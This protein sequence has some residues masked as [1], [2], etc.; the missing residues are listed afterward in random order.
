MTVLCSLKNINVSFGQKTIFRNAQFQI[1]HNDKIG[2]IGL[3]GMGKSTLFKILNQDFVPDIS[4]D[5][6]VF[7]KAT[8][9]LGP[10][11][12]YSVFLVPQKFEIPKSKTAGQT[13]V[14]KVHDYFLHYYPEFKELCNLLDAIDHKL[15]SGQYAEAELE[16]LSHQRIDIHDKLE[17]L[18]FY[19]IQNSYESYLK[20]FGL[21]ALEKEVT[22]LSGGEQR[23]ILLA[24]GLTSKANLIL[25][26]EPT[27]HL[28]I[29]TINIF[30]DEILKSTKTHVIISHDRYLLSKVTNRIFHINKGQILSYKGTYADYMEFVEQSEETRKQ[31]LQKL[32]NS[33]TRELAWMRQGVRA[34]G[35]KSKKRIEGFYDLS[36][37]VEDLK[38][39]AKKSMD[40]LINSSQRKTRKLCE[41]IDVDF[42]YS[43][44][45]IF[46]G[47]TLS[48]YKGDK[49]GVLG[50]NGVGK[51]TL[52]KII[53]SDLFPTS[54]NIKL[55]DDLKSCYF[56]QLREE[57]PLDKTP[58]QLLGE[59]EDFI[60]FKNGR[61]LHVASYFQNYLFNQSELYRPLS[62]FSGGELNRLQLAMNLK[63]EADVWIFDEPTNDL[64]IES[65][66]I[67]EKK[68]SEFEGTVIVISHDRT[69][70][71]NVTNK[72]W[73]VENKNIT[74]FDV[75]YSQVAPYLEALQ[76]EKEL[77]SE[78]ARESARE[79]ERE[80]E[81]E[82]KKEQQEI[83]KSE[84][85]K[86]NEKVD[87]VIISTSSQ[88]P[89]HIE[90]K[91]ANVNTN[92]LKKK[93][94]SLNKSIAK[95][96]AAIAQIDD[97]LSR[98]DYSNLDAEKSELVG[99]LSQ[100]KDNLEEELLS[101][102]EELE[103]N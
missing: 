98:F 99:K 90:T 50:E 40:V 58:F 27:N 47:L 35:T 34:R 32:K 38:N 97:L 56:S 26:D 62:S 3:N 11:M 22:L 17:H 57:L 20:A 16:K 18:H 75:G 67:L 28:D 45:E 14:Y 60:H 64:D 101:L 59:G 93:S 42:K 80:F 91:T 25:W 1:E 8:Q 19:D 92:T 12:E 24:L 49:I 36:S 96:E 13:S 2:L 15:E 73:M 7:D 86:N 21:S 30:E 68:L 5:A 37:K 55:A 33:L 74:Y 54:G 43:D 70:L 89:T 76:I 83:T 39:S 95:K 79:S 51:S 66:E 82:F 44:K 72:I 65:I 61:S 41:F 102:Y 6:F 77:K 71:E 48:L 23:K 31:T 88:T 100:K 103:G 85:N 81:R 9:K 10:G 52:M 69:F 78:F 63:N 87:T 53:N 84:N 46:K 4:E 29:E 94:D